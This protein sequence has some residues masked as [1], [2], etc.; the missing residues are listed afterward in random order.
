[1]TSEATAHSIGANVLFLGGVIYASLQTG[2]SY[3]MSPY[4]NGTKICHIRLTI[5]I[6]SAIS[7]IALLVLMPIAMYQWSTSSHGYWT[8]RKM[9]YDKGF[10]L[11]V[12]SSVA[13]WTMAIMFLA[14]Y[15][16][17]IREFQKVCVH[18]RVQ[19][20]VQHFDEEPPE[21]NVS[22]ATERTPIVM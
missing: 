21:S 18:L 3:K 20:L 13:E 11:M 8:G 14:Y 10:D 9:P 19:L 4:Y 22:V 17:F 2:L 12:A 5:T 7:L 1:M 15:F 16:T 6:L